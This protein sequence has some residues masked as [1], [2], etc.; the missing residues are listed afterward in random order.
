MS[1]KKLMAG[2]MVLALGA[3][4]A[5]ATPMR[6]TMTLENAM[7][8]QFMPEIGVDV[9]G[10]AL[11]DLPHGIDG[12]DVDVWEW[13][14][15]ARLGL[16]DSL[17][18]TLEVPFISWDADTAI[19]LRDGKGFS[20][21]EAGLGHV[22]LGL[23][24]RPWEDIFDYVWII[25][26]AQLFF[27]TGDKDKYL[28]TGDVDAKLGVSVGTTVEDDWHFAVDG[29]WVAADMVDPITFVTEDHG[30]FLG[31]VSIMYD[32]FSDM[33]DGQASIFAEGSYLTYSSDPDEHGRARAQAGISYASDCGL[34]TALYGGGQSG[35]G[36]GGFGGIR[37]V[38]GF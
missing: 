28:G 38:Y 35:D 21:G 8:E 19:P 33:I 20:D 14:I 5:S 4:M 37:M 24:W 15:N 1:M 31:S 13:D 18:L 12:F 9:F 16:L 25:P 22:A 7:P 27:P 36:E 3:T 34:T 10:Y 32:L 6:T 2:L 29:S 23:Q 30:A 11:S 17:A 26:H